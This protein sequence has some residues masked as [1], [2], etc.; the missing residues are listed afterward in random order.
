MSNYSEDHK[1]IFVFGAGGHAVSVANVAIAAGYSISCFVDER[2][3]PST[4][5]GIEVVGKVR[6]AIAK[7][8]KANCAIAVGD[9]YARER[10][11]IELES[12][13]SDLEFPCLIHPSATLSTFTTVGHGT[14]VMPGAVIGPNSRVGSF[15]L[16]NT[17]SSIDHD[18][19]MDDF[20]SL[21]PGVVT[22]GTVKIGKR[23]AVSIGAVIKH[24]ITIGK[25]SIVGANSYLNQDI[26]DLV[27][28]YGNPAKQIRSRLLGE[29]Y[30]K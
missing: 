12:E 22:G 1:S 26:T 24:G 3:S 17:L 11:V 10:V 5:L 14:I 16:I 28:A 4:L 21:A 13:F 19:E 2:K 29:A 20:S 27:V 18:C 9:N 30:L 25:D 6:E 8:S 15:C 23:S 7:D